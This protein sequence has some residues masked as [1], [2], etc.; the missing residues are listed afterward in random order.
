MASNG[1]RDGFING[2]AP[3][4]DG[5]ALP[6]DLV[7]PKRRRRSTRA[8]AKSVALAGAQSN[9][10]LL[11]LDEN[12]G[13]SS[14]N[15]AAS[16]KFPKEKSNGSRAAKRP[17]Q[18]GRSRY[19]NP[20]QILRDIAGRA[21]PNSE[22]H[23]YGELV[24]L[25]LFEMALQDKSLTAKMAAIRE[26]HDRLAGK[27]RPSVDVQI[28]KTDVQLYEEAVAETLKDAMAVGWKLSREDAIRMVAAG[29][30]YIYEALGTSEAGIAGEDKG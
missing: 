18:N 5:V 10:S 1:H 28:P 21:H 4:G 9:E 15:G 8:P 30:P 26:I 14:P 17:G 7:A 11:G 20:V 25:K 16:V 27:A 24:E 12:E 29:D 6:E 3:I 22:D 2:G 23:T 19:K 13:S